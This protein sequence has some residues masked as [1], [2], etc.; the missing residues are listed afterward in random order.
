[1]AKKDVVNCDK[2]RLVVSELRTVDFRMGQPDSGYAE[3]PRTYFNSILLL[4]CVLLHFDQLDNIVR[5]A[6]VVN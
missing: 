5:G 6:N 2:P 1:M 4:Q 3:S